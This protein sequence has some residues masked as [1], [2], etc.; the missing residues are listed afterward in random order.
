MRQSHYYLTLIMCISYG[1][2]GLHIETH[3]EIYFVTF[4]TVTDVFSVVK[5]SMSNCLA[6]HYS[7]VIMSAMTSQITN[8]AIVYST[9]YRRSKK[10]S[11]LRVT[12]LCEGKSPMTGES[13][14]PMASNADSV[15]IWWRHHN[16]S[17]SNAEMFLMVLLSSYSTPGLHLTPS[18][19]SVT[20]HICPLS[21]CVRRRFSIYC[22]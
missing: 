17:S 6:P 19:T 5:Q 7:D 21:Q 8:F 4:V 15:S 14:L 10:T 16:R 12:G 3:T 2:G 1:K 20:V 11:K 18:V 13:P 9:V 22:C